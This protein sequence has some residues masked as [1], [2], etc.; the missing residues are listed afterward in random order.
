MVAKTRSAQARVGV[1]VGVGAGVAVG[2]MDGLAEG[3]GERAA[4]GPQAETATTISRRV[5][6][7]RPRCIVQAT[8]KSRIGL[9]PRN[10]G[11][12][13]FAG[14]LGEREGTQLGDGGGHHRTANRR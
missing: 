14:G 11:Q 2:V 3:S 8:Q 7:K 9:W 6:E 12:A 10:E 5:A 1:G 4:E 13:P